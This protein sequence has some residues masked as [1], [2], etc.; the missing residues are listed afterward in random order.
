MDLTAASKI[1][2]QE[3]GCSLVSYQ[4]SR[5]VWTVGYGHI[6][7]VGPNMHITQAQAD[8]WRLEDLQETAGYVQADVKVPLNPNQLNALISFT[9]NEG[10]GHLRSSTLLFKLNQ[11]DF[12]GAAAEFQKWVKVRGNIVAGL[13]NRRK[14]EQELFLTAA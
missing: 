11:G 3:E 12:V 8:A 5:G 10:E 13:V 9:F 2:G 7:G 14:L 6:R 1:V 4:D